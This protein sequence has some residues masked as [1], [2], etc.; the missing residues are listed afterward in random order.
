MVADAPVATS[1]AVMIHRPGWSLNA[2]EIRSL[3]RAVEAVLDRCDQ[4]L[5]EIQALVMGAGQE[6]TADC[7]DQG[8]N[9]SERPR[10]GGTIEASIPVDN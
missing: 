5:Q 9:R 3:D 8:P 6:S 10:G 2:N 1:V 4:R 7:P